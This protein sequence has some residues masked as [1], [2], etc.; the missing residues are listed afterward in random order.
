MPRKRPSRKKRAQAASRITSRTSGTN[1]KSARRGGFETRPYALANAGLVGVRAR[2]PEETVEVAVGGPRA[3]GA[4]QDAEKD[5]EDR[6]WQGVGYADTHHGHQDFD[7]LP[8]RGAEESDDGACDD[9]PPRSVEKL[10][11]SAATVDDLGQYQHERE[12]RDE[13]GYLIVEQNGLEELPQET[14]RV[15]SDATQDQYHYVL[16]WH[17]PVTPSKTTLR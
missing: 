10:V 9:G 11:I 8:T 2:A 7:P 13:V 14:G 12:R 17:Y 6:I 1:R 5:V 15:Q 4:A 16:P 3:S